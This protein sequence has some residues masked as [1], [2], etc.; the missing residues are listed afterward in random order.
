MKE[1]GIILPDNAKV[2]VGMTIYTTI[3]LRVGREYDLERY[4]DTYG[5]LRMS[6]ESRYKI[7]ENEVISID[8]TAKNRSFTVRSDRGCEST[9]SVRDNCLPKDM[10]GKVSSV[11][12]YIK[13]KDMIDSLKAEERIKEKLKTIAEYKKKIIQEKD[14]I[15]KLK[16][17]N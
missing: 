9:Y 15:K 6:G 12:K 7:I 1:L 5:V 16:K 2:K 11:K 17:N 8:Q 13:E 14:L 10:F 3:Q 4:P